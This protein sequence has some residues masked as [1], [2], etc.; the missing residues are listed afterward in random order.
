[1]NSGKEKELEKERELI[2]DNM[3]EVTGGGWRP[4]GADR[5]LLADVK[6]LIDRD[7][8]AGE[9]KALLNSA[10]KAAAVNRCCEMYPGYCSVCPKAVSML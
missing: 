4:S 10:G 3:D 1:M 5:G 7:G 9:L 8:S 2:P 6:K